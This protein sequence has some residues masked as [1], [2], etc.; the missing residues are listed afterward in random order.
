MIILC[1]ENQFEKKRLKNIH[2]IIISDDLES[3]SEEEK[4]T[5]MRYLMAEFK[6]MNKYYAD[7]ISA[8]K[9]K[10]KYFE[11]LECDQIYATLLTLMLAYKQEK[12]LCV[13]CSKQEREFLYIQFLLQYLHENFGVP[14]IKYEDWK[15][16]GFPIKFNILK[17]YLKKQVKKYR[18]ILFEDEIKEEKKKKKSKKKKDD[19]LMD[20]PDIDLGKK[21]KKVKIRR[22]K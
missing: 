19:D 20:V 21:L 17:D 3:I 4:I 14:V 6:L 12:M 11:Y 2:K 5:H 16:K 18:E 9:Y 1:D 8:K 13:V 15:K 22:I 10:N 7:E